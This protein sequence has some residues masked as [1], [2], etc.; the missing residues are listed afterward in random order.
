MY[1]PKRDELSLRVVF[2]LPKASRMGFVARIWRSISLESSSENLVFILVTDSGELT[3]A[4]YL[5]INLACQAQLQERGSTR[6]S[7]PYRFSFPR[8]ANLMSTQASPEKIIRPFSRNNDCLTHALLSHGC[9]RVLGD[10]EQV[11]FQIT[12]PPTVIRLNNFRTIEGDTLEGIDSDQNDTAV[13][14]DAVLNIAIAN[15]M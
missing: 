8:S 4:R 15:G 5:I 6:Y 13:C 14:V 12:S 10:C 9:V 7:G 3:A 2:A 1:F 11:R